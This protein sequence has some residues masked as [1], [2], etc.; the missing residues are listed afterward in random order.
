M[1]TET[2]T[3]A[4]APAEVASVSFKKW[5]AHKLRQEIAKLKALLAGGSS[6]LDAEIEMGLDHVVYLALKRE[7]Y[8][9]DKIDLHGK[10]TEEV[11]IDYRLAQE[12]CIKELN[13]MISKFE[14]SRQYNAMVGAVRAKADIYDRIIARGQEFGVLEKVPEKKQVI[15]GVMVA[16]LDNNELRQTIAKLLVDVD[17][18]T[19]KYGAVDMLGNPVEVTAALPATTGSS[20]VTASAVAA[21]AK[22]V[23]SAPKFSGTGKPSKAASGLSKAAGGKARV[24]A[25]RE[26]AKASR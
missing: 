16:G 9:Q 13:G 18:I 7:M 20:L 19:K 26:A 3:S 2:E 12:G 23:A 25:A 24:V 5:G 8:A 17:G 21:A 6:D 4:P 15:A 10:S 22:E 14:T 11:F 1:A